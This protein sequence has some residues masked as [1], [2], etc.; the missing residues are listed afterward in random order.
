ML[1]RAIKRLLH[2]A[3]LSDQSYRFM[4]GRAPDDELVVLDCETTGLNV[5]TDDVVAIAAIKI[6]GNRILTSERFEA[7]VHPDS[8]MGAEAIKI[9]RLRRSDVE[10]AP[11]VWKVLPSFMHFI[12]ARPLIGYY[13]DFDVAMLDKYI[14]PLVGIEL[15]NQRIE[16]SRLYYERKYG[17]APPN[18]S[19]D[20][21]FAAILRDLCI[22]PLGQ[23]DAFNDA[24]MTAMMF[25]Q[26]RDLTERGVRIA[27]QRTS[28]VFNPT[29][30]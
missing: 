8:E 20:L 26:L 30:A 13:I 10:A 9:H 16:V 25:V 14:L 22:P 1:P 4:F 2:Q 18:T 3:T 15:P 21:S 29:G 28:P 6:R 12:G 27:R 5:R 23:H 19:I 11:I 17:D 24:L 7:V